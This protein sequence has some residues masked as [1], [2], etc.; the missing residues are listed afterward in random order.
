VQ[1][2][3]GEQTIDLSFSKIERLKILFDERP[4][5]LILWVLVFIV[6]LFVTLFFIS[7]LR[8]RITLRKR[9]FEERKT[10]G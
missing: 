7:T 5:E 1:H 8:L 2:E 3:D 6:S 9:L 4:F 10:N